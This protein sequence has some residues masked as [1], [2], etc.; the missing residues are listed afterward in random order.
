MK[1]TGDRSRLICLLTAIVLVFTMTPASAAGLGKDVSEE[2]G[3][4]S[5]EDRPDIVVLWEPEKEEISSQETGSV[6]I[7]AAF[8]EESRG[9]TAE[10]K[11]FLTGE[12][13]SFLRE[14]KPQEEALHEK[15]DPEDRE[16]G[17]IYTETD[18]KGNLYLCF[19]IDRE[20]G[21]FTGEAF[22]GAGAAGD[23]SSDV[24]ID[25][26]E[27]DILVSVDGEEP[28]A[29][30]SALT[31]KHTK[32]FT[33]KGAEK[34]EKGD[35]EAADIKKSGENSGSK[36]ALPEDTKVSVDR[37]R[38][39]LSRNIFWIDN[40]DEKSI[41]P[42]GESYPQPVLS[43]R[44]TELDEDGNETSEAADYTELTED[45]MSQ[46][47]MTALPV[48]AVNDKAGAGTYAA[49]VGSRTLP[50]RVTWT[51]GNG[52]EALYKVEWK[53]QPEKVRGYILTE[54][55]SENREEYPSAAAEGWYYVLET[56]FSF[57]VNIR[58]GDQE[59]VQGVTDAL[60][61]N[62]DFTA[63]VEGS[64]EKSC[65]LGDGG[66]NFEIITE[67]DTDN[68]DVKTVTIGSLWKYSLDGALILYRAQ[69]AGDSE[70]KIYTDSLEEGD[71][72]A[73]SYD[74]SAAPNYGAVTDK[75][76]NGG[77]LY[78]TLTGTTEYKAEKVWLDSG[79]ASGILSKLKEAFGSGGVKRPAGEFQLW[80]YRKG[81]SPSAAAPVRYAAGDSRGS[82]V[83]LKLSGEAVQTVSFNEEDGEISGRPGLEKYDPEGYEYIYAV[84]EYLKD[85]TEDGE[86]ADHY[87]QVPGCV[88]DDGTITDVRPDSSGDIKE[89][90]GERKD[91]NT[92]LYNGGTLSNRISDTVSVKVSKIWRA[93]AFQAA[94]EDV[95]VEL[96]LYE[97]EKGSRDESRWRPSGKNGQNI[98]V[99]MDEFSAENIRAEESLSVDK[100][101]AQGKELEYKWVETGVFQGS[102]DNLMSP[103][104]T[105]TLSQGG[106][107]VV[108][109]SQGKTE[110]D[111]TEIT[112]SIVSAIDY[113]AEKIWLDENGEETEAPR[114][115]E[116]TFGLYRV[117]GDGS[118]NEDSLIAEFLM[119]GKA[120][121]EAAAI[122]G[123]DMKI[124]ETEPWKAVITP[125]EEF[126]REG[127]QY[128]YVLLELE[129]TVNYS[130]S[131]DTE[132]TEEGYYTLVTNS[133]GKGNRILV[134]KEWKDDSDI[135]HR[136]PVTIE[137]RLRESRR[138][139]AAVT[140]G[141]GEEGSGE[142]VWQQLV[143]IGK[144]RPEEVYI[145]EAK[146]ADSPV[147][148]PSSGPSRG[149]GEEFFYNGPGDTEYETSRYATENHMYEAVY[150]EP[151]EAGTDLMY[152][153]INRRLGNTDVHITKNWIDGDGS[154]REDISEALENINAHGEKLRLALRL[155]FADEE[156]PEYYE[157]TGNYQKEETDTV[158][159]GGSRFPVN[160]KDANGENTW[161]LQPLP[162]KEASSEIIFGGLPK[163]DRSG[164]TVRYKV[165]EVWTDGGG[166]EVSEAFIRENYPELFALIKEYA[167]FQK[168]S[169]IP[170]DRRAADTHE[171]TLDNRLTGTKDILWHKQW[172]DE[173][174][175]DSN[176][177]PD[178]YLD[179]YRVARNEKGEPAA[180]LYRAD[181][182]WGYAEPGEEEALPEQLRDR[183]YHWH[184]Q[185]DKLPKYDEYG[186]EITY[187]A[188]ERTS[189]NKRD[190]DYTDTG[191][192]VPGEKKEE[193]PVYIGTEYETGEDSRTRGDVISLEEDAQRTHYALKEGGTFTNTIEKSVAVQGQKLWAS[194]PSGYPSAD[195]PQ[196]T[197]T[198]YRKYKGD[199]INQETD[200]KGETVYRG[201]SGEIYESSRGNPAAELTVSE[202]AD[203]N[204]GG[205]Y[206]F[207]IKY[208]GRNTL[209]KG[210]KG[211]ITVTGE[212]DARELPKYDG[213]GRLY[214]YILEETSV[215]FDGESP[216]DSS[217]VYRQPAV[218]TYLVKN[219][220]HSSKASAAVKKYLELPVKEDGSPEAY[221]AVRFELTR[222]YLTGETDEN[223]VRIESAPETADY[224]TWTSAEVK[225]AYEKAMENYD[226]SSGKGE[227]GS[228]E[229]PLERTLV[230]KGLDKYAPNGS[231]YK[232]TVREIK[233]QLGGY[234]TWAASGD[235]EPSQVR[236]EDNLKDDNNALAENIVLTDYT[237]EGNAPDKVKTGATFLN[238]QAE[239]RETV[240]LTGKKVWEDYENAF[241]LRPE[242]ITLRLYRYA[243][244]QSGQ[245]NSIFSRE[246][247]AE[248]YKITW[249]KN[250]DNGGWTYAI[251]G[252][253]AGELERYAPNGMAWQYIVKEPHK[254]NT[255]NS[256]KGDVIYTAFPSDGDGG[257]VGAGSIV[258][259][260]ESHDGK[261]TTGIIMKEL[262]NSIV[263]SVP[264]SK[265]WVDSKG[266]LITEDYL[267]AGDITVRFAL[268]TA[269]AG[270]K[271]GSLSVGKWKNAEEY[272]AGAMSR[273]EYNRVFAGYSFTGALTGAINDAEVWGQKNYFRKLPSV[274]KDKNG[275]TRRLLYRVV[276]TSVEFET[277]KGRFVQNTPVKDSHDNLTYTY[278]FE[279][280]IFSPAYYPDG[281][282][283]GR[284]TI[285]PEAEANSALSG[286]IH[287]RLRTT[288]LTVTKTWEGDGDNIRAARPETE[289]AGYDWEA[290]FVIERTTAG[291]PK[292]GD[293]E[294]AKVYDNGEEKD[295][296]IYLYGGDNESSVSKSV[297]GL[298]K[299]DP[300]GNL[301]TYRA[302]ELLPAEDRYE[303]G[304]A[305]EENILK[306]GAAYNQSYKVAYKNSHLEAVNSMDPAEVSGHGL[307][308]APGTG[309]TFNMIP[310]MALMCA[311]LAGI[312]AAAVVRRR[313]K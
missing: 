77:T 128:D 226:A 218:N 70:G 258:S 133:P 313:R 296:V 297:S 243:G 274:I 147:E 295:L 96:T 230:F 244:E 142:N 213:R 95:A 273:E 207:G 1:K 69:S 12:E 247:P 233:T 267:G 99:T 20:S 41:R 182:R 254:E 212:K 137:V 164:K 150:P 2:F 154:I 37:Y 78:L 163:Y 93:A 256:H 89:Q 49:T 289:R 181:C 52:E 131:Y 249:D 197:F 94:F 281:R 38:E 173:Y 303:D 178:I 79:T 40:N 113:R 76:H 3:G 231:P 114:D 42:S 287:N 235:L 47:G 190:F 238:A 307:K 14:L 204:A 59:N 25:V 136:E 118:L 23:P 85:E 6:H 48:I 237:G 311:S 31:E 255:W 167:A 302:S 217:L 241:N 72:F 278:D 165:E 246:V 294:K 222:T 176:Q 144:Y 103:E 170:G 185:L 119:D 257:A 21:K 62:L 216:P 169:Y 112:N 117:A 159:V 174:S 9:Q 260:E 32:A 109:K 301:Y 33:V 111:V 46:T 60:L 134:R 91:G 266:N 214:T 107:N 206:L 110:G 201:S 127:R 187:Y 108:Y 275:E 135:I 57:N 171:I 26:S 184:A 199:K 151:S 145:T 220:Y 219:I 271:D 106:R 180:G 125:L 279:K 179:I 74:N 285:K 126:D 309:D 64:E 209:A 299:T 262:T 205:S 54:V 308:T 75:I 252:R 68:P 306:E 4:A 221:P 175:H 177:R 28:E 65:N 272:F 234:S 225:A 83:T 148:A 19:S 251:E 292:E 282:T 228:R 16:A 155:G 304:E 240:I 86:D 17:K 194:L 8:R 138:V 84:R 45:S 44:L 153:V 160:I 305:E 215:D 211:E 27:E 248:D 149:S 140:L 116:V 88:S 198:L 67:A 123:T 156:V 63:A 39:G 162:L 152:S 100:Y 290:G 195:L 284:G 224:V 253:K 186:Y 268:Q 87:E 188:V 36:R 183:R 200:E 15:A 166:K 229:N 141:S 43:F 61:E 30:Y 18:Q 203:L 196:V 124:R 280:G 132:R 259:R 29:E 310:L 90:T 291:E 250:T 223:G 239:E 10:V 242:N 24:I 35:T 92:F 102:S 189:V 261:K 105:F 283:D 269:E 227:P 50:S 161:S 80:R 193:P 143:G 11:I 55:T 312:A 264:Y 22:F 192:W 53:L 232:Y 81:E 293:W 286:E 34:E 168:E 129:S 265:S 300:E 130:P 157:I 101:D 158:Y 139:I 51:D 172:N 298:P 98:T 202:W 58:R 120:D 71:Y 277:E 236:I 270:K 276:E 288:E 122:E 66:D 73:M 210:E 245:G 263:L 104:G 191:Y 5:A 97:R 7:S 56:D 82:I 115:A 208:L 146:A 13:A 121:R